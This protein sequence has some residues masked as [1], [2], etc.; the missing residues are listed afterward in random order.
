MKL[1]KIYKKCEFKCIF[2]NIRLS[3]NE[4]VLIPISEKLKFEMKSNNSISLNLIPNKIINYVDKRGIIKKRSGFPS[5]C[6]FNRLMKCSKC[7]KINFWGFDILGEKSS[8]YVESKHYFKKYTMGENLELNFANPPQI[9]EVEIRV[10]DDLRGPDGYR[11]YYTTTNNEE[12]I[13]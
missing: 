7:E 9:Q 6:N 13:N 8:K 1:S 10:P 3:R 2:C 4:V 11:G 12:N 5:F